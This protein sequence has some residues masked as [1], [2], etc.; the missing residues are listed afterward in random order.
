[1]RLSERMIDNVVRGR[2]VAVLVREVVCLSEEM[3]LRETDP[4]FRAINRVLTRLGSTW[5]HV[6]VNDN[7]AF[8]VYQFPIDQ[9]RRLVNQALGEID[10]LFPG[11][12]NRQFR[13]DYVD[14]Y[15]IN[16]GKVRGLL[17]LKYV[18]HMGIIIKD[19]STFIGG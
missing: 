5:N 17:D 8:V 9:E 4:I 11:S 12:D 2:D 13:G 16:P 19:I 18:P 15:G 3:L 7:S 1:M 14:Q 10:R 6:V